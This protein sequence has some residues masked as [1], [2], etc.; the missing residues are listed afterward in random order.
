MY[1]STMFVFVFEMSSIRIHTY[2]HIRLIEVDICNQTENYTLRRRKVIADEIM[3][4]KV[5]VT[6]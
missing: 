6:N 3:L 4:N 5:A 1:K 2:I